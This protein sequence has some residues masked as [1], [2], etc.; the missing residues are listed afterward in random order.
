MQEKKAR[1][2][3]TERNYTAEQLAALFDNLD[4]IKI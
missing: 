4:E 2:T 1:P 3:G